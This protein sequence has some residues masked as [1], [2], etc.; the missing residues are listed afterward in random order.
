MFGELLI[1]RQKAEIENH[2]ENQYRKLEESLFETD[3]TLKIHIRNTRADMKRD[4]IQ[5]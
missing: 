4:D 2:G 3:G 5:R 1:V